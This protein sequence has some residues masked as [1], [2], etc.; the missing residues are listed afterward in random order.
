M[1]DAAGYCGYPEGRYGGNVVGE[2]RCKGLDLM[3]EEIRSS[4]A[5]NQGLWFDDPLIVSSDPGV[6]VS[7]Y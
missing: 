1:G 7:D 4:S 3:E 5:L 6:C 2:F